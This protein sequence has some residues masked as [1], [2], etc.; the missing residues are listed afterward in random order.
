MHGCHV[1]TEHFQENALFLW[2]LKKLDLIYYLPKLLHRLVEENQADSF[3][4]AQLEHLA[5][6]LIYF[7]KCPIC[8]DMLSEL[9]IA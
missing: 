1:G 3:F 9:R 5:L 4:A 7:R 6:C 8:S 2:P